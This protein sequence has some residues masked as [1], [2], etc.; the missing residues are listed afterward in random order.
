VKHDFHYIHLE[1]ITSR[2]VSLTRKSSALVVVRQLDFSCNTCRWHFIS[3]CLCSQIAGEGYELQ[4]WRVA[5]RLRASCMVME[6]REVKNPLQENPLY[7]KMI[8]VASHL[9]LWNGNELLCTIGDEGISWQA[10]RLVFFKKT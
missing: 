3:H 9:L 6:G 4:V 2:L 1:G 8:H 7:T 5:A 10:E